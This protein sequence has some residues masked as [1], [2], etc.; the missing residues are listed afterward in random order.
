MKKSYSLNQN[1]KEKLKPN[2]KRT[3]S[4]QTWLRRQ[5]N[6]IYVKSA[7]QEGYASRAAYKLIEINDK[8]KILKPNSKIV[9]LGAA[10]G[11]WSQVAAKILFKNPKNLETAKL[12]AVDLLD[13]TH[14]EGVETIKG[15]FTDTA[16]IEEIRNKLSG[17]KANLVMSDMAPNTTGSKSLDHLRI[18]NLVELTFNFACEV[19]ADNGVMIAKVFQGGTEAKLLA[20]IKQKFKEVGH[21]KPPASRK[22]SSEIY[23]IARGFKGS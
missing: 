4:S 5:L 3:L 9:D 10:P 16:I 23:L 18:M 13:I 22:E 2:K 19:L 11:G 6:D 14:I 7:K 17:E 15:D 21:F 20:E 1:L 8:Y 12:I